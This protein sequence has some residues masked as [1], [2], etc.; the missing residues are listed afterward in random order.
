M[1]KIDLNIDVSYLDEKSNPENLTAF[2]VA[3]I[4]IKNAFDVYSKTVDPNTKQ[5]NFMGMDLIEC[6]IGIKKALSEEKEGIVEFDN[7]YVKKLELVY[8]K[9]NWSIVPHTDEL[10]QII[11]SVKE[12]LKN[13]YK[14]EKPKAPDPSKKEDKKEETK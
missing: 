9:C 6:K 12:A 7:D 11:M 4:N 14:G 10:F 2:E 5:P 1:K 13:E 8:S 3:E